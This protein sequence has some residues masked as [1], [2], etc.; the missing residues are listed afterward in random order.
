MSAATAA[1]PV[2]IGL[3]GDSFLW[4][5]AVPSVLS[6]L[7]AVV[8]ALVGLERPHERWNL[9]RRYQR[10][11]EGEE[12]KHRFHVP[13]YQTQDR[14]TVL[15]RAVAQLQLDLHDEWSGLLP[16]GRDLAAIPAG[17]A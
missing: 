14:D 3:G 13:P 16:T 6:A 17:T 15:A 11:L 5:K 10:R 2:A 8:A 4:G 12:I 7:T 9:Y 1:V